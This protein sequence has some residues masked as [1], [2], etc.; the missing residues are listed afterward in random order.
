[1]ADIRR[2][3]ES[4]GQSHFEPNAAARIN[5]WLANPAILGI[6]HN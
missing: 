1:M 6:L 5:G 4:G 2:N 3:T